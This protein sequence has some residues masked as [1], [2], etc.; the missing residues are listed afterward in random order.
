[1]SMAYFV[2]MKSEDQSTKVGAIIVNQE[3]KVVSLGF[4]DFPSGQDDF[5]Q[6]YRERPRKYLRTEHAERN[7]IY[8]CDTPLRGCRIYV[9]AH[10]CSACSRGIIQ[11]GISKV[12]F[13][14]NEH[15]KGRW[16][17]DLEESRKMLDNKGVEVVEWDGKIIK[18]I[19]AF[20]NG[21][22]VDF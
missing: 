13:H 20:F 21:Q 14:R 16:D 3:N 15:L 22:E 12:I 4:N 11:K 17:D 18:N 19:V 6:E 10:P 5:N 1:M 8:N 9:T 2:A 7:A